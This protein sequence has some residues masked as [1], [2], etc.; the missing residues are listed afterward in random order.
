[1]LETPIPLEENSDAVGGRLQFF[2]TA[3]KVSRAPKWSQ[4]I[5][6][7]GYHWQWSCSPPQLTM[8]KLMVQNSVVTSL[9]EDL[10]LK[11]AIYEV[12]PQL[13]LLSRIFEVP[14]SDGTFRLV[15]DLTSLNKH[16]DSP[17]F[18][19]T[20]H[21]TLRKILDIPSWV[22]SIDIKDVFMHVPMRPNLHRF[23][24]LSC[25]GKLYL[26]RTL[27]FGL[28]TAPRVFTF[29]MKHP[30]ALLHALGIRAIVYLDDMFIWA[31]SQSQARRSVRVAIQVLMVLG[32]RINLRK[33]VLEPSRSITW[34][35]ITWNSL[36]GTIIAPEHLVSH[37]SRLACRMLQ[38]KLVSRIKYEVFLGLLNFVGQIC[39]QAR[40]FSRPLFKPQLI[41]SRL[42]DKIPKNIPQKLLAGLARW[43]NPSFLSVPSPCRATP[44]ALTVWT[45]ASRRAWGSYTSSDL[46][47]SGT[48]TKEQALLHI[49]Q[50]E[51]LAVHLTLQ[52]LPPNQ[53][54]LIM[55]DN[56]TTVS[57]INK[58]GSKREN[59]QQM[60]EPLF[61][62][63]WRRE[64]T[65]SA[66]Y[67][68]GS[69]NVVADQLSRVLPVESEWQV[70]LGT[71][72]ALMALSGPLQVD[73]F[74]SPVNHKLEKFA[75]P[76]PHPRASWVDA[77][78]LEWNNFQAIYL[79]PP[80][81]AM[82]R[83]VA[84]LRSFKGRALLVTP[85]RPT[86]PWYPWLVKK[87]LLLQ[88]PIQ[89]YQVVQKKTMWHS[90][91]HSA[92]WIGWIF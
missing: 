76:F 69:E 58:L 87:A 30:L 39:P 26:F 91:M 70:P 36:S 23:L 67:I 40:L 21:N 5:V 25:H 1:M 73:L 62:Q 53:S 43:Q 16:I 78:T 20:N 60:V 79:F 4:N 38:K 83:V 8:P 22:A 6:K 3:W 72:Q 90:P 52:N 46:S 10:L 51:I 9:V 14:K 64:Q 18:M 2:A 56:K 54:F 35:G 19:M 71:F 17:S 57:A 12:P 42:E 63:V 31:D 15:I 68:R 55:S 28:T 41:A 27:P 48:W 77:F 45:D 82:L 50:L 29:I 32:F 34:L 37:I 65:I 59:I 61:H 89:V 74:A 81:N 75:A 86:A 84:K 92:A 33:S 44:P 49:N 85:F 7:R 11:G 24:G 88:T 47:L 66:L 13:C 80:P